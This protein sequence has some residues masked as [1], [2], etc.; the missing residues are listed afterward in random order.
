[1]GL[2]ALRKK[3]RNKIHVGD[4][5]TWGLQR[6][7]NVVLEVQDEGVVVD[8]SDQGL[9]RY[10]VTWEGGERGRGPGASPLRVT[11]KGGA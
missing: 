2:R 9:G 6:V 11:K 4:S 3:L 5:V 7:S 10:F 8:A 1:M